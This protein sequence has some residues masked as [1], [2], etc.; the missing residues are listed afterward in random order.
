MN[1]EFNNRLKAFLDAGK[2]FVLATVIKIRGSASAKP[3]SKALINASGQNV[4]GWV[5]GGCA[6]SLVRQE[7]LQAMEDGRPRIV[8]VDLEDEVLGVGMPCGGAMDVY[9]EPILPPRKLVV[10]GQN[11]LARHLNLLAS[12][13]GYAVTV[14][15]PGVAQDHFPGA[16]AV[17]AA[18]WE[19]L[20][21]E[22]G[23]A[24]IATPEHEG[25]LAVLRAGIA[26]DPNYFAF[27]ARRKISRELLKKI[28]AEGVDP[29][30]LRRVRTPA[31]LD[32]G[33]K[34]VEEISLSILVELMAQERGRTGRSLRA[35]KGMP[36]PPERTAP[37][38][39][40]ETPELLVVGQGRLTEELARLG[41]LM[42]YPVTINCTSA[43]PDDYPAPTCLIT[44]DLDF[45]QFRITPRTHVVIATLH[46]G[47]HLSMLKAMEQDAPYIGLIASKKRSG[48][49]LEFLRSKGVPEAKM[50]NVFAP[51]GLDIGTTNP[52]EIALS[53]MSEIVLIARGG[54]G[55]PLADVEK[56]SGGTGETCQD[57]FT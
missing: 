25:Q 9:I 35:V 23:D 18:P 56:T 52:A 49:V 53:I 36:L 10:A 12:M 55:K 39:T 50:A 40:T 11:K 6:E 48:L 41:A 3:G 21:L 46:K 15:G 7:A 17:I 43:N 44:G 47:D 19:A 22:S 54:S 28:A 57:L 38:L 4:M 37:T 34:T 1:L 31:G 14:H 29:A 20:R 33:G 26:S 51:A 24:M 27:V 2:P 16:A 32:L 30:A 42:G 5:G 45:S 8:N 13:M